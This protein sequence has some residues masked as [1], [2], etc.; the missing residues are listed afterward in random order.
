MDKGVRIVVAVLLLYTCA[1]VLNLCSRRKGGGE[2][3]CDTV[4]VV[5]TVYVD[6]PVLVERFE[7]VVLPALIDTAAIIREFYT[8]NVF[9]D[10][11]KMEFGTVTVIDTVTENAIGGR[12]FTYDLAFPT[13][14]PPDRWTFAVGGFGSRDGAGPVGSVRY[15]HLQ[16]MGGYDF[17]RK[18]PI[19]GVQYS[20]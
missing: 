18:T 4:R 17:I 11:L 16:L 1:L 12:I 3:A 13:V 14:K 7:P 5:D 19:F 9:C 2:A 10:T 6:R 20:F 15:R 8:R